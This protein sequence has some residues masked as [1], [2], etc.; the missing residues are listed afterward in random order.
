MRVLVVGGGGREHAIVHSFA[1]SKLAERIFCA[2]GNAGT[3][4]LADNVPIGAEDLPALLE[5]ASREQVDL[6]VIGP[7]APLV[8]GLTDL[9]E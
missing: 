5:F 4:A 9:F 8:A 7:E 6:T 2:P 1:Q 3:A